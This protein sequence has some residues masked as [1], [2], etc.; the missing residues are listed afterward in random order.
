MRKPPIKVLCVDDHGIVRDGLLSLFSK[1]S[2]IKVVAMAASGEE[3]VTLFREHQP[4]ITLMDLQLP[5]MSG[6]DA[7]RTILR[8]FPAARIIVLTMYEGEEDIFRAL[9]A[10]AVTYLLKDMLG[11]DLLRVM[12]DV[13]AGQRPIHP[14]IQERLDGRTGPG[15]SPREQQVIEL[16]SLGMRNKEIATALGIQEETA[17]VY[18]KKLFAKLKVHDRTAAL[19]V[20]LQRG[21]LHLNPRRK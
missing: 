15:L 20:A 9:E 11:E 13:H 6:L 1:H 2:D 4:D 7:I 12:R 10:G 14:H 19:A 17:Q 5:E 3:A 16:I 21:I 8:E 18:V